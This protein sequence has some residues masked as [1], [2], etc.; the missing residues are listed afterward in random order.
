MAPEAVTFPHRR[1]VL[2]QTVAAVETNVIVS[3]PLP[4]N[5]TTDQTGRLDAMA[6]ANSAK[7]LQP[8]IL[9]KLYGP[10]NGGAHVDGDCIWRSDIT[11]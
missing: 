6:S 4:N 11:Y 10:T 7:V 8:G 3:T 2:T 5:Y 9:Y 1:F